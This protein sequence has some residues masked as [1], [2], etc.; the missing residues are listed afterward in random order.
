MA[1]PVYMRICKSFMCL[2]SGPP[3][4][5]FS[6]IPASLLHLWWLVLPWR[7]L[8]VPG[9]SAPLPACTSCVSAPGAEDA[10][11]CCLLCRWCE[12]RLGQGERLGPN[13]QGGSGKESEEMGSAAPLLPGAA[14]LSPGSVWG[15][16][17]SRNGLDVGPGPSPAALGLDGC[18]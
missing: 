11:C 16:K 10:A 4:F 17:G 7:L 6:D 5:V 9:L 12:L 13:S 1:F 2:S 18:S 8:Q 3:C 15:W 14:G